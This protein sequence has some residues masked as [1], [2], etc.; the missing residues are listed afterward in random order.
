MLRQQEP[1]WLP[2]CTP[3]PI[4]PHR[5]VLCFCP[6]FDLLFGFFADLPPRLLPLP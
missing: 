6:C 1:T 2:S 4:T 5:E 3:L